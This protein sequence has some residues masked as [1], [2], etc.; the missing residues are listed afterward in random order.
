M[1]VAMF[2]NKL[3]VEVEL[4]ANRSFYQPAS[5]N[6]PIQEGIAL[7]FAPKSFAVQ[8]LKA[9]HIFAGFS[10]IRVGCNQYVAAKGKARL[11]IPGATAA[12][13]KKAVYATGATEFTLSP[14]SEGHPA[15]HVGELLTLESDGTCVVWFD[16]SLN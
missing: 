6:P 13:V 10:E 14:P 7:S 9:G 12:D 16:A 4:L 8:P 1:S 3:A 15:S 2:V 5:Y 11:S